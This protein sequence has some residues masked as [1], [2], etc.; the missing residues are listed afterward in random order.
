MFDVVR[1]ED[2]KGET[3]TDIDLALTV[4]TAVV[5]GVILF[6]ALWYPIERRQHENETALEVGG[7]PSPD[8]AGRLARR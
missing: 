5:G 1:P 4:M 6:A 8:R 2:G 7:F 3:M